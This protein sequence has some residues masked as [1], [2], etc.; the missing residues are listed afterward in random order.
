MNNVTGIQYT[1]NCNA[2]ETGGIFQPLETQ[3]AKCTEMC[4]WSK[5]TYVHDKQ[6]TVFAEYITATSVQATPYKLQQQI[7]VLFNTA[8]TL[9]LIWSISTQCITCVSAVT[10][11][12]RCRIIII[13]WFTDLKVLITVINYHYNY[14]YKISI[15]SCTAKTCNFPPTVLQNVMQHLYYVSVRRSR[16]ILVVMM[17][18]HE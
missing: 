4:A 17:H 18:K 1:L 5:K 3:P 14:Y 9:P 6:H 16:V 11:I 13:Y 12:Q 15:I 10:T 8:V 2:M 7:F